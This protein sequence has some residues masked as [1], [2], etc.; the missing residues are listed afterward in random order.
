[1]RRAIVL[2]AFTAAMVALGCS[3]HSGYNPTAP[4]PPADTVTVRIA[5][6]GG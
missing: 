3:R 1:M 6:H 5:H 2:L 4:K